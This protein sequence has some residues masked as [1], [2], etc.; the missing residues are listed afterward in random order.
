MATLKL[1]DGRQLVMNWEHEE[2]LGEDG[3]VYLEYSGKPQWFLDGRPISADFARK[4]RE[5]AKFA[6]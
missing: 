4:L 2:V 6:Q 5:L 1:P 3:R